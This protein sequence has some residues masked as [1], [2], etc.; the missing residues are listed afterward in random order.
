MASA[1]KVGGVSAHQKELNEITRSKSGRKVGGVA[2][3]PG[4]D[5]FPAAGPGPAALP[6]SDIQAI[7]TYFGDM[8]RTT[9]A[10][11]SS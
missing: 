3:Q 6:D 2:R 7:A 9:S 1:T 8:N 10:R 4:H 11:P 5:T